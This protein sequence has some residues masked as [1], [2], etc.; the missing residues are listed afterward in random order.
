MKY[1]VILDS[2]GIEKRRGSCP[3]DMMEIQ[4]GD[5]EQ[6][7]EY[8]PSESD[9]DAFRLHLGS[10]VRY[11]PPAPEVIPPTYAELRSYEYPPV[12]EQLDMIY[13][14]P[15]AWR[16]LIASIKAKYPKPDA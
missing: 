5:G 12:H 1:Y 6:V 9:P 15:D 7:I 4:A 11:D 8:D 13:H 14:D 3:D 16:E 2:D 10:L